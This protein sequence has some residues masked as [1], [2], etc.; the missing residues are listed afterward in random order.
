MKV[1]FFAMHLVVCRKKGWCTPALCCLHLAGQY[2]YR[3]TVPWQ[4]VRFVKCE[5]VTKKDIAMSRKEQD[6]CRADFLACCAL[7]NSCQL[8]A[9]GVALLRGYGAMVCSTLRMHRCKQ[10]SGPQ[11]IVYAQCATGQAMLAHMLQPCWC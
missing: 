3:I 4:A 7:V 2:T 11:V 10:A 9:G 1:A 5:I 8:V 6:C